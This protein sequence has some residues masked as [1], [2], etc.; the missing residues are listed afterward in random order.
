MTLPF[1]D[2]HND[3]LFRLAGYGGDTPEQLFLEGR[4][5]GHVDL[6]RSR[7]GGMCGGIFALYA[8]SR[9]G[10]DFSIFEGGSYRAPFPPDVPQAEA[11]LAIA[12]QIAILK[13][14]VAASDGAVSLCLTTGEV[15]QAIA[16][17]RYA[18]VL[19]LEGAEAID[20]DLV[21]LEILH[22]LGLRSLGPVWSRPTIFA[23]GVPMAFPASPDT[24]PGL[25]EAGRRLVRACNEMRIM[26]DLA[27]LNE[28]GFW[29]VAKLSK[30]PLV[31]THSN[32]HR[33]SPSS[34]NLTN[35]QLDAIRDSDGIV[36]INFATC[37]L[38]DDGRMDAHTPLDLVVDHMFALIEHLGED[39]VALGSDFDGAIVPETI[40]D[41]TGVATLFDRLRHR[42][43]DAGLLAKLATQNWIRVLHE[44]IG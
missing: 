35:R 42:G 39:R 26:I 44:T 16:V 1:F 19:H 18:I 25:T 4:P 24:G 14:L 9:T 17:N 11:W 5:D 20:A 22:D 31:A 34:R 23:E 13:R 36:G 7:S 33:L 3:A 2:G 15:T 28:A 27:H 40:G 12:K 32:V 37:F 30:A 38:R 6:P 43:A 8:E 29:D 10:L 41:V 21:M